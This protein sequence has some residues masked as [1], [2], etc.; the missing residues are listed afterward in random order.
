MDEQQA[1]DRMARAA[2][3]QALFREVNERVEEVSAPLGTVSSTAVFAC[4]CAEL[5]CMEQIEISVADYELVRAHPDHFIVL[6][7]H[8]YTD[9]EKVVREGEGVVVV[10]KIG[11][12]SAVA[13][14]MN[15]RA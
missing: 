4:E 3:N 14:E 15:P 1:S 7:G 10:E 12:A 9:V 2:R 11:K 5:S 13:M 8:V 6:P